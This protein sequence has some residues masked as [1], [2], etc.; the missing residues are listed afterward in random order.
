MVQIAFIPFEFPEI[1]GIGCAFSSRRGGASRLPYHSANLSYDVGDDPDHV[2][3][4]RAC[5]QNRFRLKALVD[6]TQVHGDDMRLD[7]KPGMRCEADGLTTAEPGIGL[8]IK[9]ADCQP[10]LLAHES[11]KYA[12]ALH[13][14][15]RGNKINF[16]ATGV[17]VF[18]EHY[19]LKPS[20]LLAVRGPSL[21]PDQAE[22]QNFEDDFGP[23]FEPWFNPE[24]RTMNLWELTR[25]QLAEA[26]L[27]PERIFGLDL[28]TKSREEDFFSY[29]RDKTTGRQ[30]GIIWIKSPI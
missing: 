24:T 6:C 9:T 13:A 15:W 1:P 22:F 23:G 10:I 26:G 20:E 12:A 19:G 8:M 7:A 29:R 5:L 14:G 25:H 2:D 17:R 30:A 16:P 3:E 4:N 18:C 21:G 28:C 11:G 27:A